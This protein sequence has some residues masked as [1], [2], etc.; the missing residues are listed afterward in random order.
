MTCSIVL[1]YKMYIKKIR[2][3][4]NKCMATIILM[5]SIKTKSKLPFCNRL[6]IML[7]VGHLQFVG[8]EAFCTTIV[9]MWPHRLRR[10]YRPEIFI[11]T[12]C[13]IMF[14][15]GLPMVTYVSTY[16]HDYPQVIELETLLANNTFKN[17]YRRNL[18]SRMCCHSLGRMPIVLSLAVQLYCLTF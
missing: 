7:P 6:A 17:S 16:V 8:V 15:L 5:V 11:G 10:G 9:D 12:S 3:Q 2:N 14:F 18:Y 1:L 13:V 4:R